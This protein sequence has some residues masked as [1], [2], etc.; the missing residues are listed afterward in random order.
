MLTYQYMYMAT[1]LY[2]YFLYHFL[3]SVT[4]ETEEE[5]VDFTWKRC[6]SLNVSRIPPLEL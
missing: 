2:F 3:P 1:H 4:H 6:V 5:K